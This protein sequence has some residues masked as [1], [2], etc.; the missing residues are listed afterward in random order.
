MANNDQILENEA[1]EQKS[2]STRKSAASAKPSTRAASSVYV[3][4]GGKKAPQKKRLFARDDK[5]SDKPRTKAEKRAAQEAAERREFEA[6]AANFKAE[7][8]EYKVWRGAFWA[9]IVMA[10][11]LTLLSLFLIITQ[12]PE[13]ARIFFGIASILVALAIYIDTSKVRKARENAY[14]EFLDELEAPKKK[15]AKADAQASGEAAE[16]P[17]AS[18][19][20]APEGADEQPALRASGNQPASAESVADDAE[21]APGAQS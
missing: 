10:I 5:K 21:E 7:T 15:P 18:G 6:Q 9:T 2:G 3:S 20:D 8:P 13:Q 19:S 16:A 1:D 14:R 11:T 4:K 12:G 17:G